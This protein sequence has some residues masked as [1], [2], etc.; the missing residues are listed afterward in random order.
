MVGHLSIILDVQICFL[1]PLR[2]NQRINDWYKILFFVKSW[3]N[4]QYSFEIFP[5]NI[6]SKIK[7]LRYEVQSVFGQKGS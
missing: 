1:Y 5:E 6:G 2:N 7:T 4:N 3:M